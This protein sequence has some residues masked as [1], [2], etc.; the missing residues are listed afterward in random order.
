MTEQYESYN[1]Y[2]EPY[3]DNDTNYYHILTL[4]RQPKG[5]LTNFTKLMSIKNIS[6][7]MGNLNDNYCTVV[8]KNSIL[9]NVT[10]N[11]IQICTNDDVTE[12]ID[13]LTNNNYIINE[14]I[15]DYLSKYNSK[16]LLFNFK[17]K[18]N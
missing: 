8:I 7:K 4:N 11:K 12:V 5:P 2:I 15:T 6:T 1:L 13:F 17:Y 14:E 9:G 10:H 16:K 3:Y 18:I